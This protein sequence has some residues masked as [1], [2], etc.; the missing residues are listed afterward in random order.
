MSDTAEAGSE[1][2]SHAGTD[3][4]RSQAVQGHAESPCRD[5]S[6]SAFYPEDPEQSS[7]L[8]EWHV[9]DDS[10]EELTAGEGSLSLW[11]REAV[12]PRAGADASASLG[13][14][15][16]DAAGALPQPV[17]TEATVAAAQQQR[18]VHAPEA[19]SQH[20]L[21]PCAE[22]V[23]A[24]GWS[25]AGPDNPRGTKSEGEEHV[26]AAP[27][28]HGQGELLANVPICSVTSY[29]CSSPGPTIFSIG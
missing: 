1:G 11:G 22:G 2:A 26:V 16:P 17:P 20:S 19:S 24:H 13:Q 8:S 6:Y 7:S 23:D 27:G 18:P 25:T 12:R 15:E 5:L 10:E 9:R 3:A 21:A 29:A 14:L 28:A 4:G